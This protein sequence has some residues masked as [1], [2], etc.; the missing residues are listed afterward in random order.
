MLRTT[1]VIKGFHAM[2]HVII[3]MTMKQPSTS[4]IWGHLDGGKNTRE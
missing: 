1:D 4:A 2:Y 3:H